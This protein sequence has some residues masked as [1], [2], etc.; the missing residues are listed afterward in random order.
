MWKDKS[1]FPESSMNRVHSLS[2]DQDLIPNTTIPYGLLSTSWSKLHATQLYDLKTS[3]PGKLLFLF[4]LS[5]LLN[6][7]YNCIH[8]FIIIIVVVILLLFLEFEVISLIFLFLM[9]ILPF[10]PRS[11]AIALSIIIISTN[12]IFRQFIT[13]HFYL[14]YYWLLYCII[15]SFC[16]LYIWA[17]WGGVK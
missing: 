17:I 3:L 10:L 6:V 2:E 12:P 8:V 14:Q 13:Y 15:L 7:C 1:S 9:C 11:L 16:I 4:I 5:K